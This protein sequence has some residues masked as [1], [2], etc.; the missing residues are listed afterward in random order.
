[1][2]D[3]RAAAAPHSG[4]GWIRRA[5]YQPPDYCIDDVDLA[6]EVDTRTVVRARLQLRR[7][8]TAAPD[9]PLWLDA[10]ALELL[11][12]AVDGSP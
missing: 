1:M 11:S 9:A 10:R 5:D 8:D 12:I 7:S 3:D 2:A 6:V 4:A